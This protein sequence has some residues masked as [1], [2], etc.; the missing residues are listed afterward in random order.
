MGLSLVTLC[1]CAQQGNVDDAAPEN[2]ATAQEASTPA[3]AG[4]TP[5]VSVVVEGL[6]GELLDNTRIY[7]TITRLESG[8]VMGRLTGGGNTERPEHYGAGE[9]RRRHRAAP[10][11]IR[12]ALMPFGYYRPQIDATLEQTP[13]GFVARYRVDPGPPT[14][15]ASADIQ[16]TGEGATAPAVERALAAAD[17]QPG[18]RLVHGR[19]EDTKT[20]LFEAA[21]ASGYPLA[22]WRTSEIRVQPDRS[23]ADIALLLD[24]GPRH[25]FGAVEIEQTV[26]DPDL[27]ARYVEI[28]PG[29]PYDVQRLLQLQRLLS[30]T[31]YFSRVEIRADPAAATADH[32]VPVRVLTEPS[33]SQRYRVSA[34]YGTDTGPRVNVGVLLRHLNARGH[35][36]RADVMVS[37]VEQAVGARYEIPIRNVATDYLSFSAAIRQ[38]E[39]GDADTERYTLGASQVVGWLGFRRRLYLHLEREA[40]NFGEGPETT[41]DLLYPGVELNRDRA[42][43]S[44]YARRGYALHLDARGGTDAVL[45]EVAFAR[46]QLGASWL[47]G[48]GPRTRLLVSGDA[49]ILW[50]DDFDRLPPSQR[51]FAGGDRSVRGYP[52]QKIGPRNAD[53]LVIGGERLLAASLEIERLIY[54]DYGV[55]AFVDAGDAFD[56][57]PD[58]KVGAGVGF[59]WRSPV[60]MVRLDVAHP[61]DDPDDD[62]RI[63]F[64][65]GSDL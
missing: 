19:Y 45:S 2:S 31:E 42:D 28:R 17:L 29:D 25:Y 51:F 7:L 47:R 33:K 58:I 57:A 55:A 43:D 52:Y 48:L 3:A 1:A 64:T 22:S 46:L 35:R 12:E 49:G 63:H 38:E 26:I 18:Q 59:R 6:E 27:A 4:K 13:D 16:V 41:T 60:G 44:N 61:F 34:G 54:G 65:I 11:Q 39:I 15:I 5:E 8:S 56:S 36:L 53:G 10:E 30:E 20:A 14:E 50:T 62:Y 23:R 37:S 9:V 24:T 21:Y 32:R 40:F